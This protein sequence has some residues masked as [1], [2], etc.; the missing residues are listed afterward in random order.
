VAVGDVRGCV[1]RGGLGVVLGL[2]CCCVEIFEVWWN[3]GVKFD[4]W[5]SVGGCFRISRGAM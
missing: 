3:A 4:I 2:G 1:L 5:M